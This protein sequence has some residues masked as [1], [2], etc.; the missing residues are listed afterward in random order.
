MEAILDPENL[1][2]EPSTRDPD[3]EHPHDDNKI[4]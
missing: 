4:P 1:S 3:R 2:E